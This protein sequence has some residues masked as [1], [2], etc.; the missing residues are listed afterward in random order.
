MWKWLFGEGP[1]RRVKVV[2]V[3]VD[4]AHFFI[5][6]DKRIPGLCV[7]HADLE[8][9]FAAVGPALDRLVKVQYGRDVAYA[10]QGTFSKFSQRL[11]KRRA[12]RLRLGVVSPVEP[13]R[14]GMPWVAEGC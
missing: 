5:S 9:A 3:Y 11:E 13:T 12:A 10:P 7:A 14:W 4:G 1:P 6:V 2:H 8:T